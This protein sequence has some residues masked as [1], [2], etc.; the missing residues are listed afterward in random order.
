LGIAVEEKESKDDQI[1]DAPAQEKISDK[2]KPDTKQTKK[3]EKK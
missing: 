2:N 3:K 1:D